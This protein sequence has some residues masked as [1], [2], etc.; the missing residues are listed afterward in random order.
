MDGLLFDTERI[1]WQ[2]GETILQRRGFHY[3]TELQ[4]RMMG[5]IGTAA[6]Q[7]MI[8]FHDLDDDAEDL[9]AESDEVY[10][11]LLPN[12]IRPM[13]GLDAW[14]DRL[15]QSGLPFAL[16]TSSRRRWVDVIFESQPWKSELAFVLTGDDVSKGKPH[17]EMYLTAA[18]RFAV[19]PEQ[20]LVLEDSGNGT[21]AGVAAGAVVVSVP[22]PHTKDQDFSG[23]ALI[24]DS[25]T[26]PRLWDLLPTAT[27]S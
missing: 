2:V 11:E 17:P 3:T 16:T 26:D 21:K 24:A 15:R 12:Q 8:D 7:Q 23:A 19:S 20:M 9:L 4:S 13:P 18:E 1:Y 14:V 25:L 27:S 10:G 6:V 22:S 5:R